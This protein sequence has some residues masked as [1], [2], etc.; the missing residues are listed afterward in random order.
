MAKV[1]ENLET[2]LVAGKNM[3]VCGKCGYKLCPVTEDY[4]EYALKHEASLSKAQPSILVPKEEKYVLR[5]YYCPKCGGMFEVDMVAKGEK[6][7][8][9]VKLKA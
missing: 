2:K 1:L 3:F 5:E 4:R 8:P 7:M 6:Q 9:S